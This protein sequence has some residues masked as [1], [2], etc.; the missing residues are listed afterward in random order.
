MYGGPSFPCHF[1]SGRIESFIHFAA[2]KQTDSFTVNLTLWLPTLSFIKFRYLLFYLLFLR[3]LN[4]LSKRKIKTMIANWLPQQWIPSLLPLISRP[5]N[6]I[7][8]HP[9]QYFLPARLV[10]R[11]ALRIMSTFWAVHCVFRFSNVHAL[12]N[13]RFI[14]RSSFIHSFKSSSYYSPSLGL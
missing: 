5:P 12:W 14:I 8:F 13:L 4:V 7:P 6:F 1:R 10:C 11:G 9:Y 2:E 3:I